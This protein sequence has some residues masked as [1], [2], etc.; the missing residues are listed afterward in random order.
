MATRTIGTEIVLKGEKQFNDAMKSV[1]NNLKNLRTDMARVSAEFDGNADSME[2]LTE[3]QKILEQSVDQHKAK[4][5]AL[6]QMYE[7]AKAS[8]GENSAAADKYRQQL[9]QATVALIKEE[10]ALNK[11]REAMAALEAATKDSAEAVDDLGD[12]SRKAEPKIDAAGEAVEDMGQKAEKAESKLPAIASG[13]GSIAG[14][15]IAAG[16]AV[17]A[18]AAGLGAAAITAMVEFANEAAEAAK[19]ASEAGEELSGSQ[20]KWLEYSQKLDGLSAASKSAKEALGGMLLPTL[21]RLSTVGTAYLRNFA[22]NMEKAGSDTGKQA[23]VIRRYAK[24]GTEILIHEAP[25][26]IQ[27]GRELLGGVLDGFGEVAPDLGEAGIDLVFD[28][29]ES[30]LNAAPEVGAGADALID[31]LLT[32]LDTRGPDLITSAV[33]V[34]GGFVSGLIDNAGEV[35]PVAGTLILTLAD[36]L[37]EGIPGFFE[38]A[39]QI[40]V[41]IGQYL[42]SPENLAAIAEKAW[43]IGTS[44]V[45]G[46]WEGIQNAW[47]IIKDGLPNLVTGLELGMNF[48]ATGTVGPIPGHASG[49]DYVPYDNYL[50]RLHKGERV[51][52]AA[53]AAAYR[54]GKKPGQTLKQFNMTIHTQSL[55][56]EDLDML[57]DY[58]NRKLGDDS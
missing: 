58:V 44:L 12:A 45:K 15:A 29:L 2:A 33:G 17:T 32:E 3:K 1:N 26:Y 7:K 13:L 53:E 11:N 52:T 48:A 18:F 56:K 27:L 38:A 40:I 47:T 50:A 51:L 55:S 41:G 20:K 24:L 14:K 36:A 43:D 34:L 25:S 35:I 23:E 8:S 21:S 49:L 6:R 28:F 19:A 39:A 31:Q 42:S 22:S 9:N 46:I 37:I 30:L 10:N 4:V 5:D 57:V 16:A 54:N